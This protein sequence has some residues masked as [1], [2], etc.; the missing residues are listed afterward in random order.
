M[1]KKDVDSRFDSDASNN[2]DDDDRND[3]AYK[4]L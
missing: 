2:D 4:L 1:R 3:V